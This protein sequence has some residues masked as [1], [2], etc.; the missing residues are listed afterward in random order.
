MVSVCFR[1]CVSF[2][3]QA[4]WTTPTPPPTPPVCH[5]MCKQDAPYTLLRRHI[6]KIRIS[7]GG[8]EKIRIPVGGI[9]NMRTPLGGIPPPQSGGTIVSVCFGLCV[10]F[11]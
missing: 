10:S 5:R 8:I 1:L 4:T 11:P 3:S 2:P 9:S 6:E 7:S